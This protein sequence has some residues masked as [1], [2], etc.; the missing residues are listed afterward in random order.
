MKTIYAILLLVFA[1]APIG[2]EEAL[3]FSTLSKGYNAPGITG[4][5]EMIFYDENSFS[6][7]WKKLAPSDASAYASPI[8]ADVDFSR[9]M[10]ILVSPGTC[11]TGGYD[12]V[13]EKV[14][15]RKSEIEVIVLYKEPRPD[16]F[17][18]E[19]LTQPYHLIT[20]ER[21]DA[22]ARFNWENT[23]ETQ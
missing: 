15:D 7:A 23:F 20:L 11:P 1:C 3:P 9:E 16:E 6:D 5:V 22:P 10:L 13:I 12:V 8:A 18:T 19:A 4:R 14:V 17:V 2:G 21:R